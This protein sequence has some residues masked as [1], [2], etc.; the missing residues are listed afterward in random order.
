LYANL[1]D[2]FHPGDLIL[3][4]PEKFAF[5]WKNKK[6]MQNWNRVN[7]EHDLIVKETFD[8]GWKLYEV[9]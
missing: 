5:Q 4:A 7:A 6:P 3:F 1:Y 9:R 2:D 8:D